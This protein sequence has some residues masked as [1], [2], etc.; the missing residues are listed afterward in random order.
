MADTRVLRGDA[1]AQ[2][3]ADH[4]QIRDLFRSYHQLGDQPRPSKLELFDLI[5]RELRSHAALEEDIFYPAVEHGS[6]PRARKAVAEALQQHQILRTLI[7]EIRSLSPDDEGFDAKMSVLRET[8]ERH[9]A[10]EDRRLIP[11]FRSLP[12]EVQEDV[13]D[14]LRSRKEELNEGIE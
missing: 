13:S 9:A 8:C 7:S 5:L 2:L 1:V 12:P 4:A 3:Q 11:I 14:R 6:D 10:E